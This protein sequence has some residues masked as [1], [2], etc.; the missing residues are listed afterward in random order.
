M[1][2]HDSFHEGEIAI[3]ERADVRDIAQRHAGGFY[4]EIPAN[5]VDWIQQQ[6]MLICAS[7]NQHGQIWASILVGLPGFLHVKTANILSV[8]FDRCAKLNNDPLW[9][10]L[11]HS[12]RIG[13]L[14]IDF[15]RRRRI[16]LNGHAY[17]N[18]HR[19]IDIE[20]SRVYRNCP[21][22]IQSRHWQLPPSPQLT[23]TIPSRYGRALTPSHQRWIQ[24]ADTFFVAT[25][26]KAQGLDASHR[27]GP[28]GFVEILS[29]QRLRI[30][31][32]LGNSM[33][34][35]LGNIATNAATGLVFFD[36][37]TNRCLQ[38]SGQARTYWLEQA[39]SVA[40]MTE[41]Y[42]EFSLREWREYPL[43]LAL[44]WEWIDASPYLPQ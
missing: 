2:G 44:Q 41:R 31:D 21:K 43:P 37:A 36:F 11:T 7:E 26:H 22:Y 32:Y 38:L 10:N 6:I 34:N 23:Q 19:G 14:L 30:P 9:S 12:G 15:A 35:T 39:P 4:K 8:D 27:G 42:W 13:T 24:H 3:Q 1:S 40:G 33:F 29:A 25:A 18:Q 17:K 28:P 20:V 16:R 5:S